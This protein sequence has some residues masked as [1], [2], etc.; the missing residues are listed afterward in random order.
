MLLVMLLLNDSTQSLN[1][2]CMS[3]LTLTMTQPPIITMVRCSFLILTNLLLLH[4]V[5]L[6]DVFICLRLNEL[7]TEVNTKSRVEAKCLLHIPHFE[8]GRSIACGGG[9]LRLNARLLIYYFL[10]QLVLVGGK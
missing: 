3:S 7:I 6:G 8:S 5:R 9:D 4:S 1:T 2:S 10:I